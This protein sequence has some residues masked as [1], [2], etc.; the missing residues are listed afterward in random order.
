MPRPPRH[1]GPIAVLTGGSTFSAGE[2]FTQALMDRPGRTCRIGQPA[3]TGAST[4]AS[5]SGRSCGPTSRPCPRTG[6]PVW[7]SARQERSPTDPRFHRL[8][9]TA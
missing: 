2:T 1:T 5:R 6:G 8:Q 7:F 9:E 4:V 3:Q